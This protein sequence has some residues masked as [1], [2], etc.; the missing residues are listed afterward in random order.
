MF[1]YEVLTEQ[2]AMAERFQLLKE[3]EYDAVISSSSD[4][5]S[6]TGNP[7]MDMTVSVY[8]ENGKPHDVRDFLVFTKS[9]MWKVIHFAESAG[10]LKIYEE[11]NLCSKVSVSK[12]VRVQIT[13]EPGKEITVDKLEGKPAGSRYPDKNKV[14]DYVKKEYN[15]FVDDDVPFM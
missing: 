1:K 5:Q 14:Q 4:A 2:E 3:G 8:D 11:G 9:M 12:R 10:L 15:S 13:V 7:M 6:K